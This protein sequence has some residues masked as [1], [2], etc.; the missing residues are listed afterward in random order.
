MQPG[1]EA[2]ERGRCGVGWGRVGMVGGRV[3]RVGGPVGPH[4]K[5]PTGM[6]LPGEARPH[7]QG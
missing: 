3:G 4:H 7:C 1:E 5:Q 2:R 6:L